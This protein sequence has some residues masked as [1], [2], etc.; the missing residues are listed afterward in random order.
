MFNGSKSKC[1]ISEPR[2][3]IQ[4]VRSLHRSMRQF[5][6]GGKEIEFVDTFV[7]LGHV[8]RSDM[9]DIGDIENQRCKFIGQTNNVLC[10][11]LCY[12]GKLVSDVK[13]SLFR[14]YC[15]SMYGSVLW[16][17]R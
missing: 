12:F 11:V 9:E 17:V 8:V 1:L 2:K 4:L 16:Y 6:I 14:S 5:A 10:L 3:R 15:S 7:H 13:Y